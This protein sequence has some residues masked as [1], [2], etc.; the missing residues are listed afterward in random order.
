MFIK[1]K[2][3]I[4]QKLFWFKDLGTKKDLLTTES[5]SSSRIPKINQ[6]YNEKKKE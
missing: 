5:Q 6:N 3:K 4:A 1:H 2:K